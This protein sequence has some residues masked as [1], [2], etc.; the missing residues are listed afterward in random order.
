VINGISMVI[1]YRFVSMTYGNST[2]ERMRLS[3]LY[4]SLGGNKAILIYMPEDISMP[5]YESA[6]SDE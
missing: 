5:S 6:R 4:T 2:Q 3:S 1:V